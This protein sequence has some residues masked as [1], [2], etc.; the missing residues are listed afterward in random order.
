MSYRNTAVLGEEIIRGSLGNYS[1]AN[2]V[3]N[4]QGR[5]WRLALIGYPY[6]PEKLLENSFPYTPTG[7]QI[8]KMKARNN[9]GYL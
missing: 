7:F 9:I 3:I 6:Q 8:A 2:P 4:S 1:I 5:L